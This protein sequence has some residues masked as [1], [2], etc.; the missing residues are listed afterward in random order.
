M[1]TIV[2]LT[3]AAFAAL[4]ETVTLEPSADTYTFPSGGCYGDDIQLLMANKPAAG[5]PDERT[6]LQW[7]LAEY[8][9]RIVLFAEIKLNVFFQCGS[10]SGTDT[11]LYA[12]TETWD[13]TWSGAHASIE[14]A[15]SAEYFFLGNGWHEIEV[16]NLVQR[17]LSG[18][19]DNNGVSFKVDGTYPYTNCHSRETQYSPV[20][21]ITLEEN[22]LTPCTWAG[23]KRSL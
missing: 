6:M 7:D 10:G 16:T 12:V 18:D 1:K 2:I 19:V 15:P 8:E 3:L 9:G 5:H 22:A 4:A 14:A 17:W 21:E 13:E 11:N 20:L 23:I